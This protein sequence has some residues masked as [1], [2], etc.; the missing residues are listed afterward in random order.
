VDEAMTAV[1]TTRDRTSGQV[2][3]AAFNM[4][5]PTP[6]VPLMQRLNDTEPDL[7]I[8]VQ[9]ANSSTSLR[10]LRQS[11]VDIVITCHYGF[12]G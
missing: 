3:V 5:I 4:G 6:A 8:E 12:F 1:A 11:E 2:G 10:L 7:R 9:Q